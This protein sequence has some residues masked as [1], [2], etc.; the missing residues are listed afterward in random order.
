MNLKSMYI[1]VQCVHCI[2]PRRPILLHLPRI[3]YILRINEIVPNMVFIRR[4]ANDTA[5]RNHCDIVTQ[6]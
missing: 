6:F 5:T 1:V 3:S 2:V 4:P